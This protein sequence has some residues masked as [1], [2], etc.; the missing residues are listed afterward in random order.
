MP[1]TFL[2]C[3]TPW[4]QGFI[5]T[6]YLQ[7]NM[8]SDQKP[9]QQESLSPNTLSQ[10]HVWLIKCLCTNVAP[11]SF[12][13]SIRFTG[14]FIT[15]CCCA[16]VSHWGKY[17]RDQQLSLN[18][19]NPGGPLTSDS[20]SGK[21]LWSSCIS[22]YSWLEASNSVVEKSLWRYREAHRF[23]INCDF[24]TTLF[25]VLFKC[26]MNGTSE[27]ITLLS[28]GCILAPSI[29]ALC[30]TPIGSV[31]HTPSLRRWRL[32]LNRIKCLQSTLYK[33]WSIQ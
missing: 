2:W 13:W 27:I 9:W 1:S 32:T 4:S 33:A 3:K 8:Q 31:W 18:R 26:A 21:T 6:H 30:L 19:N 14:Y 17:L 11:Q 22:C 29:S 7:I 5:L 12:W 25:E 16:E 20:M 28:Y 24:C 10:S 15:R 23:G